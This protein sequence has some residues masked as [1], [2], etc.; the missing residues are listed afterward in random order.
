MSAQVS[1][2]ITQKLMVLLA[3]LAPETEFIN[4]SALEASSDCHNFV[5]PLEV[6]IRLST[7]VGEDDDGVRALSLAPWLLLLSC[8]N[9]DGHTGGHFEQLIE[10]F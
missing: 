4:Q 5:V 10:M 2:E 8:F 1:L 3:E 7:T 6:L 9:R